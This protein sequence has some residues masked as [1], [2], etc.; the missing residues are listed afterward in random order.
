VVIFSPSHY[1]TSDSLLFILI[2]DLQ[3]YVWYESNSIICN[4]IIIDY[5]TAA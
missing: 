4:M 2:D 1:L 5:E 3:G